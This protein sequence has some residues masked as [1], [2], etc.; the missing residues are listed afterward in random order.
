MAMAPRPAATEIGGCKVFTALRVRPSRRLMNGA[1]T[2]YC[3]WRTGGAV[4]RLVRAKGADGAIARLRRSQRTLTRAA[5][6]DDAL[7]A[8]RLFT[9][10]ESRRPKDTAD[11]RVIATWHLLNRAR[12]PAEIGHDEHGDLL[13]IVGPTQLHGSRRHEG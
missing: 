2:R 6:W 7:R 12:V 5:G 11:E 9:E 8:R 1:P 10:L 3:A 13:V 4:A